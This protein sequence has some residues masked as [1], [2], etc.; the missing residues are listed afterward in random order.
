VAARPPPQGDLPSQGM[1]SMARHRTRARDQHA[2]GDASVCEGAAH[3]RRSCPGRGTT[4]TAL[5]RSTHHRAH[6]A[7]DKAN[8]G[9]CTNSHPLLRS[10]VPMALDLRAAASRDESTP[11][12]CAA[13]SRRSRTRVRPVR[14]PASRVAP[15]DSHHRCLPNAAVAGGLGGAWR[16]R[17]SD[18]A[19]RSVRACGPARRRRRGYAHP[20]CRRAPARRP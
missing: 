16:L 19:S 8:D 9:R 20:A 10:L 1:T 2:G 5:G 14:K 11:D 6:P 3:L 12:R 13:W 7:P 17:G 4:C 18:V 15:P